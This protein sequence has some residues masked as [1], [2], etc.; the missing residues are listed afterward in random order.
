VQRVERVSVDPDPEPEPVMVAFAAV[1]SLVN[2][3]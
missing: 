1:V 2:V 3:M